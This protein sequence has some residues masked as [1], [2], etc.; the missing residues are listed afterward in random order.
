[1]P[2]AK[3]FSDKQISELN[4]LVT[5]CERLI[6][7]RGSQDTQTGVFEDGEWSILAGQDSQGRHGLTVSQDG[8]EVFRAWWPESGELGCVLL[9]EPGAWKA[10]LLATPTHHA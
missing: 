5:I 2:Y 3:V 8:R 1:M 9:D 7:A 4:Q 6:R 10:A